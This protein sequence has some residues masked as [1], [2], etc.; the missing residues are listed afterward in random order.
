MR[1]RW[2]IGLGANLG[3]ARG[4]LERTLGRLRNDPRVQVAGISSVW[5]SAPVDASGPDFLNAVIAIDTD[6]DPDALL[7]LAQSLESQEG[8][9]RPYQNAP[10]TLDVDLLSGESLTLAT[11]TLTLP[12]P[13]MHLRA[14]V[15][16]PLLEIDPQAQIPGRGPAAEWLRRI[17]D[18]PIKRVG[19]LQSACSSQPRTVAP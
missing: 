4:A 15:L 5:A 13:R 8:R 18:Q 6:L 2:M 14:F 10:R 19:E 12:H 11:A 9:Q 7:A 3:D 1:R 16:Q 17:T